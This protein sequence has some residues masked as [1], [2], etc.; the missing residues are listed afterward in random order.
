MRERETINLPVN[1]ICEALLAKTADCG[2][3]SKPLFPHRM[4]CNTVSERLLFS[5]FR[6]LFRHRSLRFS[7]P[8]F[9]TLLRMR[10]AGI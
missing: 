5:S 7:T 1:R 2:S 4:L 10:S 3:R 9:N 6:A 8:C